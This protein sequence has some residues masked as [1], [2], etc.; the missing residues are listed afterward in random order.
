MRARRVRH[1]EREA[2]MLQSLTEPELLA[3]AVAVAVVVVSLWLVR[4]PR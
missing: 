3:L 2:A 1:T 4:L